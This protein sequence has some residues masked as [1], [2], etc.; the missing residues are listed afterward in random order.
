MEQAEISI[1]MG[2][3]NP[4]PELLE[5]CI[6]SLIRQRFTAWELVLYND[7]SG[8][9]HT[10]E[11]RR[12]AGMDPRILC[13]EGEE[14]RGLAYA[15]N[16]CIRHSRAPYIARMDADDEA[17]PDRLT[18]EHAL[19]EQEKQYGWV[20]SWALLTDR[21]GVWGTRRVPEM[22]RTEDFLFNSPFI[23]PSVLFRREALETAGGYRTDRKLRLLE[24]YDLFMRLYR[25]GLRG[26][27]IQH[28]LLRYHE[29]RDALRRR[30]YSRRI[31]EARLRLE[32]FRSLGILRAETLPYVVK[33]LVA[34]LIPAGIRHAA[35]RYFNR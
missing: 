33:P 24:D 11:V 4:Q 3:Y 34:G 16:L 29:D 25:S 30:T 13:L 26:Y 22:P 5:R 8:P 7:G 28:P 35:D 2:V 1:A 31:R 17:L 21:N 19:L 18:E 12:A 20:G 6:R 10:R 27:N 23:H 9:D 15:L 32:G 14:N